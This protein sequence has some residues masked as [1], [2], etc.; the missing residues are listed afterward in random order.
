MSRAYYT[1]YQS[2][3]LDE[4]TAILNIFAT[5]QARCTFRLSLQRLEL[6]QYCAG[7]P[8]LCIKSIHKPTLSATQILDLR[9]VLEAKEVLLHEFKGLDKGFYCKNRV[10]YLLP[11]VLPGFAQFF[12]LLFES[13]DFPLVAIGSSAIWTSKRLIDLD[14]WSVK[15]SGDYCDEY[16]RKYLVCQ[17]SDSRSPVSPMAMLDQEMKF[18]W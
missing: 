5:N 2:P 11:K 9:I 16:L 14:S 15:S 3:S 17:P 18:K 6:L 10:I 12:Q 8:S 4:R 13:L 1:N 7:L